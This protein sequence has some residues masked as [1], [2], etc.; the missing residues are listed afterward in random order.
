MSADIRSFDLWNRF[1]RFRDSLSFPRAPNEKRTVLYCSEFIHLPPAV[2]ASLA[3]IYI[4]YRNRTIDF[5]EI[6]RQNKP[7]YDTFVHQRRTRF[8]FVPFLKHPEPR[9]KT[10]KIAYVGW[11]TSIILVSPKF[12]PRTPSYPV[13]SSDRIT[14]TE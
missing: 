1:P 11:P 12:Q 2:V 10:S 3:L 5:P 8:F 13:G 14:T 6:A 4:P 7:L 9:I